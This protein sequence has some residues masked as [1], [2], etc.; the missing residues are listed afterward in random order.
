M[1]VDIKTLANAYVHGMLI[2]LHRLFHFRERFIRRPYIFHCTLSN[3]LFLHI[4]SVDFSI[5]RVTKISQ[6]RLKFI[7]ND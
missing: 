6:C 5:F 4:N 3:A 7:L 2:K 1:H